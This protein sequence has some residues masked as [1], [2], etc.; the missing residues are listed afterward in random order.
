MHW[1]TRQRPACRSGGATI[2]GALRPLTSFDPRPGGVAVL[3]LG[4]LV[5]AGVAVL[6]AWR[7]RLVLGLALGTGALLHCRAGAAL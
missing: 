7:D 6:L 4:P 3:G 1:G 2:P 5:I